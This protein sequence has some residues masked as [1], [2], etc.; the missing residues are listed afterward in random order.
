MFGNFP[1]VRN[2][3]IQNKAPEISYYKLIKSQLLYLEL[4]T[5]Q[6]PNLE[7]D[8]ESLIL[9]LIYLKFSSL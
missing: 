8:L 5:M 7:L 6:I 3:S 4:N 1:N 9:L 2:R